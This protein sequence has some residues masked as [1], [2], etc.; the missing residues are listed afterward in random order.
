MNDWL[1]SF[2]ARPMS[3]WLP[4]PLTDSANKTD[5]LFYVI[6]W[7]TGFFFVLVEFLLVYFLIRYRRR[8]AEQRGVAVHGNTKLEIIWTLIPALILVIIGI[9][10]T[11]LVYALQTP[12]ADVEE[13]DVVGH[14]WYWEFKYPNGVDTVGE[15]H[16]P[17]GKNVLFRIT[18]ADVI[19]SF[20]IPEFRIKQDAVPGRLTEFTVN[21]PDKD[22]GTYKIYC[23]EYCGTSH[24]QML[25]NM[26]VVNE[27]SYQSWL[28]DQKQKQAEAA[29]AGGNADN[30]KQLAA[31]FGCL[32]CHTV[33]GGVSA[34]PTWKGLYGADVQLTNGSTVKA[35]E[36]YLIESIKDPG[37]KVVKGFGNMMP[38]FTQ[39]NEQQMKDI[40]AYIQSLK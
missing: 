13:I 37:A 19:H 14:K 29:K 39:L 31:Q 35:D 23:A 38:P 24:S 28:A 6:T 2:L 36:A 30:G 34:G 15:L 27:D 3:V 21:V 40:V 32:T 25:A 11:K 7:I 8:R 20:Y 1:P 4:T 10:S 5:T 9:S 17:A 18:S 33:D 22:K 26:S 12:P 16:I